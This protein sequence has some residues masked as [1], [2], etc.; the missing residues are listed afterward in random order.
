MTMSAPCFMGF[1]NTGVATVLST[2]NGTPAAFECLEMASKSNTSNLGFPKDS[3]KKALV[4]F[5]IAFLKL[6]GLSASTNVVVMPNRG[7][8][9]FNKL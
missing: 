1:N 9:T 3:T 7:K 6:S 8:V 4:L 5:F 2:I